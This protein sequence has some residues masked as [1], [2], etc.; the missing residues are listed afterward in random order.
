MLGN[1]IARSHVEV[2]IN[3]AGRRIELDTRHG[4][5]AAFPLLH[6]IGV[7]GEL[8]LTG[9][10]TVDGLAEL[11]IAD[12]GKSLAV[13]LHLIYVVGPGLDELVEGGHTRLTRLVVS[14][15]QTCIVCPLVTHVGSRGTA[16]EGADPTADVTGREIG[17]LDQLSAIHGTF[18]T[19]TDQ[20]FL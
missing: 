10:Q 1:T 17:V 5:L 19:R 6:G 9:R 13:T 11:G 20:Y 12:G 4:V 15:G 16:L 14:P 3:L 7:A 18:G 2:R 8:V